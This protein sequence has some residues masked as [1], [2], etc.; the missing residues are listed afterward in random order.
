MENEFDYRY[1][2]SIRKQAGEIAERDRILNMLDI[3][4]AVQYANAAFQGKKAASK[5]NPWISKQKRRL[6]KLNGEKLPDFWELKK[7]KSLKM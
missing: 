2:V 1:K 5:I 7:G 3:F 4:E 6:R